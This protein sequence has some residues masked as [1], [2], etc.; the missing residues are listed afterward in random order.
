MCEIPP[1][2]IE[3]QRIT[4]PGQLGLGFTPD[5][6]L[7]LWQP[8]EYVVRDCIIDLADMPLETL[9]EAAAVTWGASAMF[10]RCVIRGA[11]KLILCG[12]GDPEKAALETGKRVV[13][14]H[15]ILEDFGRRGVE[16]QAGMRVTLKH[17][18]VRNWGDPARHTVRDFASWARHGGRI[19]AVDTV[20]WQDRFARPWRQFWGDFTA[21]LGQAWNDEGWRGLLRLDTYSP[22][23]CW[24][25]VAG[26]G[27]AVSAWHC[28]ANRW[29]ITLPPQQ[30]AGSRAYVMPL[31][32]ALELM[33]KRLDADLPPPSAK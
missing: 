2:V 17:C 25:L 31:V 30:H 32:R 14:D 18:L 5:D 24:G 26:P 28:W 8:R 20:F 1:I 6:G 4:R 12:S 15:C 3:R 33:A 27:G 13:F 9:D 23:V 10:L 11:G 16:A 21:R 22:G 7:G 19:Y 29:W